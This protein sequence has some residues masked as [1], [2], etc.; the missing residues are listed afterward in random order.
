[1][2]FIKYL[3]LVAIVAAYANIATA[4]LDDAANVNADVDVAAAVDTTAA[5]TDAAAL[6]S[7]ATIKAANDTINAANA[8]LAAANAPEAT[9]AQAAIATTQAPAAGEEQIWICKPAKK[10]KANGNGNGSKKS[11]EKPAA[12][13]TQ[14]DKSE[15][16]DL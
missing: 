11:A 13:L 6:V 10:G 2:K 1:M 3:T 8:A 14:D 9:E 7:E 12:S 16:I 4:S 5:D 15:N